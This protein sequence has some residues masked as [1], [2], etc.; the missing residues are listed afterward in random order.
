MVASRWKVDDA[1][2]GRLMATFYKALKN[3]T[4]K[5]VALQRAMFSVRKDAACAHP[6]YWAG[7]QVIGDTAPLA[8]ASSPAEGAH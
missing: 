8:L 6:F 3:G 7:F 5:D 2:T 4:R 1:A